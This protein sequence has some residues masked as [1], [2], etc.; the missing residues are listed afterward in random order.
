MGWKRPDHRLHLVLPWALT[1]LRAWG[2]PS[3]LPCF[4]CCP[5]PFLFPVC[6]AL[7]LFLSLNHSSAAAASPG[8]QPTLHTSLHSLSLLSAPLRLAPWAHGQLPPTHKAAGYHS[9]SSDRALSLFVG[10][11]SQNTIPCSSRKFQVRSRVHPPLQTASLCSQDSCE[12]L[13]SSCHP[14]L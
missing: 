4:L 7:R 9:P 3:I 2:C 13:L 11:L 1:S 10:V 5:D 12:G 6:L 14:C 8:P